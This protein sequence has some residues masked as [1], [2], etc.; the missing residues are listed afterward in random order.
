MVETAQVLPYVKQD[1]E[2]PQALAI[3]FSLRQ[4]RIEELESNRVACH[5]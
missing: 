2:E 1:E 4:K 3:Y 5:D